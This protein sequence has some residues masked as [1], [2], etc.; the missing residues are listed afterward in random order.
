MGLTYD[1]PQIMRYQH[2]FDIIKLTES[3]LRIDIN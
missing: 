1:V 3:W 2:P